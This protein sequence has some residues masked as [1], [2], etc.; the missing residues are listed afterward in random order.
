ML[1]ICFF[2]VVLEKENKE[3]SWIMRRNVGF[4]ESENGSLERERGG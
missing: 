3:K 2:I 4:V 1:K